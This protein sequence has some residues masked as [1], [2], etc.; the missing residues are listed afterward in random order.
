MKSSFLEKYLIPDELLADSLSFV[1]SPVLLKGK[2]TTLFSPA[3][4][5]K[6]TFVYKILQHLL[7]CQAVGKVLCIFSDIDTTN[8]EFQS[9]LG[10]YYN[11]DDISQS[12]FIP[13][14]PN[15]R[16]WRDFVKGIESG[17]IRDTLGIDLVVVDSLEQ[18][19]ELVGLDFHRKVGTFFGF[20]RRLVV[21]GVSV[22]LLHHT[23]KTGVDFAGRSTIINQSDVV[24]RLRRAG[25][26][27]WYGDALKHRGAKLLNGQIDFYAELVEDRIEITNEIMDDRWG[28]VVHLIKQVLGSGPLPQYEVINKVRELAQK[29]GGEVGKHKIREAL[30]KFD[31]LYWKSQKGQ[32]NSLWYELIVQVK[33]EKNDKERKKILSQIEE[34]IKEGRFYGDDMPPLV[35]NGK[36]YRMFTDFER[37]VPTDVLKEYLERIKEDDEIIDEIAK[38]F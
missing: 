25:K 16:F 22:L 28:Y 17:E 24:Y 26:Y 9:I 21:Q 20:L 32:R 7:D 11:R 8:E 38:D 3:G 23:N 2:I 36:E 13:V 37:Y 4:V 18:F 1:F 19:F 30:A 33:V 6:S 34:M 35:Y 5:G 14:L 27:K 15:P 12:R 31:G 10:K 29:E